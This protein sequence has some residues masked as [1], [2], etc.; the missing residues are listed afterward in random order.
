MQTSLLDSCP[1]LL[2]HSELPVGSAF[3]L[4]G[5]QW[6]T[7]SEIAPSD[8]PVTIKRGTEPGGFLFRLADSDL[9]Y[10]ELVH[11]ADSERSQLEMQ[12]G[13]KACR[14]R[15]SHELFAA[16]LEKGVIL[17]ARVFGVFL[18]RDGD[19]E[20]AAEHFAEFMAAEPPLTT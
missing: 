1:T 12:G 17:R 7:M 11:P 10:A 2:S 18:T 13:A 5:A 15:L 20:A 6:Q 3:R 16:R 8:Q 14:A 9:S 19:C 4:H